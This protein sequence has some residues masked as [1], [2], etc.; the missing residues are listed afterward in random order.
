MNTT[1]YTFICGCRATS[2]FGGYVVSEARPS[3]KSHAEGEFLTREEV[4]C[5]RMVDAEWDRAEAN[6]LEQD[7]AL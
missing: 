5:A 7:S 4:R 6:Y 1:G 2:G 3:C